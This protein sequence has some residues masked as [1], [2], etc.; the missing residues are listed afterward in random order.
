[1]WVEFRFMSS[2]LLHYKCKAAIEKFFKKYE[3][4]VKNCQDL[5][6]YYFGMK[7]GKVINNAKNT[8]ETTKS[9]LYPRKNIFCN[10]IPSQ[11]DTSV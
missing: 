9:N 6:K 10:N 11:L 4:V 8:F 2:L 5:K 1:M 7:K 3:S